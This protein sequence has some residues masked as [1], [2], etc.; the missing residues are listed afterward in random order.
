MW[1]HYS[2]DG[3]GFAVGYDR[4][5]LKTLGKNKHCLRKVLYRSEPARILEHAVPR[6]EAA[7]RLLSLKS[8]HWEYEKEWRLIL[9]L[10]RSHSALCIIVLMIEVITVK[11]LPRVVQ[12]LRVMPGR[13]S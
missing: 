9:E 5:Q 6:Q 2:S 4:E 1:A 13:A 7:Y 11:P 3:T 10:R 12:A 8:D